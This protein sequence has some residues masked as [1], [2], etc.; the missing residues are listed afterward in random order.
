MSDTDVDKIGLQ[1]DVRQINDEMGLHERYPFWSRWWLIE[2]VSLGILF[3][4]V[5]L[6]FRG[7]LPLLWLVVLVVLTVGVFLVY[8]VVMRRGIARYEQPPTGVPDW[9]NWQ[10]IEVA[11]VVA[12]FGAL[13]P[14]LPSLKAVSESYY[15]VVAIGSMMGVAYLFMGQLLEGYHIRKSDR[16]AFSVG[17]LWLLVLTAV[18]PNVPALRGWAFAA[19]GIG[20]AIYHVG[21][22]FYI[23][24]N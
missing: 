12:L 11:G 5:Q 14:V 1:R 7:A 9:E 8:Y 19:L 3:S 16:Y 4:L 22:Y 24:R 13:F 17:G 18:L 15:L 21:A 10:L 2:G 20:L 23:S 6:Q